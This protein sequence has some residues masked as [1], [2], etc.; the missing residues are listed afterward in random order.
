MKRAPVAR[1]TARLAIASHRMLTPNGT[2]MSRR[3]WPIVAAIPARS[4]AR[5]RAGRG[6]PPRC[7]TAS[8]RR[9]PPG[10]PEVA[11]DRRR[12][13]ADPGRR[14]CHGRPGRPG[15]WSIAM[16]GFGPRRSAR[17]RPSSSSSVLSG[18]PA[19]W[20]VVCSVRRRSWTG[21]RRPPVRVRR[22]HDLDAEPGAAQ[23]SSAAGADGSVTS[24]A[25]R[26]GG[27]DD[28][29][30][31]RAD[32]R[33]VG[34]DDRPARPLD[35]RPLDLGLV[36]GQLG[37]APARG[38]PGGA[39]DGQSKR[40]APSVASAPGP[41]QVSSSRR[42]EPPSATTPT[43]RVPEQARDRERGRHDRR[44]RRG[45]AG[46]GRTARRSCRCRRTPSARR[47]RA[48]RRASRSAA[49][50]ACAAAPGR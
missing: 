23:R 12:P 35:R 39:D 29:R 40:Y 17:G 47:R 45:P 37:D 11:A 30:R 1:A 34:D 6:C 4:R 36:L 3:S 15:R 13:Q 26:S 24:V 19:P 33:P 9:L 25:T 46:T 28:D 43:G 8:R 50:R 5:R 16:T 48:R 21:S 44:A 38:D 41:T 14:S 2:R 7:R 10:A 49:S 32:L 27:A 31:G 42:T 22:D 20:P 18:R